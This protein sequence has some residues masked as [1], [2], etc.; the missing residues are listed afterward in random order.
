MNS[1]VRGNSKAFKAD[2]QAQTRTGPPPLGK[3]T[4]F[5]AAIP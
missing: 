2:P 3:K 5:K 4:A 1:K